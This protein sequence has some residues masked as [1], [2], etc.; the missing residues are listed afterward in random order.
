MERS[1]FAKNEIDA[2]SLF[3]PVLYSAGFFCQMAQNK[4][5]SSPASFTSAVRMFSWVFLST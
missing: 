5:G 3:V 2:L 4:K 1:R